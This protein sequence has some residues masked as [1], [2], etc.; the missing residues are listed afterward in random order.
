MRGYAAVLT[1]MVQILVKWQEGGLV[2]PASV[3]TDQ[4]FFTLGHS[5][6]SLVVKYSVRGL[7]EKNQERPNTVRHQMNQLLKHS[8]HTELIHDIFP[9][10]PAK[11]EPATECDAVKHAMR[12]IQLALDSKPKTVCTYR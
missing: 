3:G 10:Q 11:D 12:E 1:R 2:K 9:C 4:Q 5:A 7:L 8:N 6:G